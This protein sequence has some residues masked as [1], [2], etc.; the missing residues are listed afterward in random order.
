MSELSARSNK[1]IKE[2]KKEKLSKYAQKHKQ[3]PILTE[4]SF[5]TDKDLSAFINDDELHSKSF[6]ISK[7]RIMGDPLLSEAQ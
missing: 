3:K 4:D 7:E 6:M 5:C 2:N 1:S